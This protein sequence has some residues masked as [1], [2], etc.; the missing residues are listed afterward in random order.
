MTSKKRKKINKNVKNVKKAAYIKYLLQLNGYCINDI[1]KD[2]KITH[3][4]ASRAIYG[5]SKISK[6]ENWLQAHL[7]LIA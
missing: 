2:L 6:V 5:Q 7:E 4:A 1:A 3:T